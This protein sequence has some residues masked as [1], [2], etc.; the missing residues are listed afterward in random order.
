MCAAAS[1]RDQH[2]QLAC[3][4]GP[5]FVKGVTFFRTSHRF[6]ELRRV[7]HPRASCACNPPQVLHQH[8]EVERVAR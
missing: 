4:N 8:E 2:K 6:D 1:R 5:I 3:G 7:E